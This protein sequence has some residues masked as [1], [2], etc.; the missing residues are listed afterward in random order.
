MGRRLRCGLLVAMGL[1]PLSIAASAWADPTP[2]ARAAAIA[3]FDEGRKLMASGNYAEA[4]PKLETSQ[5]M[6]PGIG[7]LY[8]LSDC[9]DHQG[10]TASAWIGFREVAGQ[11]AAAGQVDRAKVAQARVAELEPKLIKLRITVAGNQ[12][13]IEVQRDREAVPQPLWGTAVPLDPGKHLV[14]ATAPGR[15]PWELAVVLDKPGSTMQVD[16]PLLPPGGPAVSPP[17]PPLPPPPVPPPPPTIDAAPPPPPPP[18]PLPD[19]SSGQR[20]WQK[21]L[22]VAVAAGGVAGIGVSV[23]LGFLAK[24]A[25]NSSV[26]EGHCNAASQCDATGLS[27]RSDAETKAGI[28]TG[29]FIGGAVLLV[30]GA[31][32]FLTAPSKGA[33]SV[34]VGVGPS[35]L[36]VRGRF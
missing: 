4:C 10:R 21:P 19:T 1:L 9:Y 20:T 31:T 27:Q 13:G 36:L 33:A 14:S 23:A 7:T 6:D 8:N 11:S 12:A 35:N 25:Q 29:V 26:S 16:I 34:Q 24:S 30:G 2:E 15:A 32:L 3:L 5:K 28:G 17:V 18:P 22:G